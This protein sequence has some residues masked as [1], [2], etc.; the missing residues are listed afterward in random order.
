MTY[1]NKLVAVVKVNEKVLREQNGGEFTIPFGSEYSV[2][3]KNLNSVRV[4][5]KVS[6]DGRDATE[7]TWLIIAP[8]SSIEL[9]RFIKGG[10]LSSG[11]KFKFVEKTKA[12]EDHRGNKED[13][14]LIRIEYQTE[15]VVRKEEVIT[16]YTTHHDYHYHYPYRPPC[17][18][19][20]Y[21]SVN[22]SSFSNGVRG[23]ASGGVLRSR[24]T[25]TSTSSLSEASS[26][27][28]HA[29]N[30]NMAINNINNFDGITVE[31]SQ[32]NQQ[33]YKTSGFPVYE[34]S[35]V[36]VLKLR[37]VVG[38]Q[39]VTAPV[40]V[41]TKRTCNYCGRRSKS[42]VKFCPQCGASLEII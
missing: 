10:N 26:G 7:D 31:G 40:T 11:N 14:G 36:I 20:P 5:V 2:L 29:Q 35:D 30:M 38:N 16:T 37:G 17:F 24:S 21:W 28:I 33:F 32:S 13:D 39:V 41:K 8:N 34:T 3:L 6:I 19:Y 1:Q 4:Q 25:N 22:N 18:P 42:S 27:P 15:K 9:E 23:S 12:I